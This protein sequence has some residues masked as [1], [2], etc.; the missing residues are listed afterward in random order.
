MSEITP[1]T[2][3]HAEYQREWYKKN[4]E[5]ANEQRRLYRQSEEWKAKRRAYDAANYDQQLQR[6]RKWTSK[7]RVQV[8]EVEKAR[9]HRNRDATNAYAREYSK[10]HPEYAFAAKATRY[11]RLMEGSTREDRIAFRKFVRF[12]KTTESITCYWCNQP[13]PIGNGNRQTDHIVP[14]SKGG[15]HHPENVCC[16]CKKCNDEKRDQLPEDFVKT[17]ELPFGWLFLHRQLLA[18]LH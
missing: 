14:I 10:K 16:A 18:A 5:H 15:S 1:Q 3:S 8:R 2:K 6:R 17:H 12:V 13:I 4:R 7:N 9:R 11:R